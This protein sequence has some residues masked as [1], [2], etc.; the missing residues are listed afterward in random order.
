MRQAG[1]A[2]PEYRA[3]KEKYTFVELVQNPELAAEVTLQPIRRFDFDAAILFSDILVINEGLG[4]RYAFKEGGG[5]QME[6][7]VETEADL[8]RLDVK[9]VNPRLEYV[10]KALPLIR[11]GLGDRTALIGFAGSPW[12]LANFMVEGGGVKEYSKAKGWF[13]ENPAGFEKLMRKLTD[14][15]AGFLQLQID[16]GVDAVQIFDSLGGVL[17]EGSFEAASGRWIREIV[18]RLKGQVPV[19][20]FSK[21]THGN[22]KDLVSTGANI[23][24]MDWNVDLAAVRKSLPAKVGVQGNLDPYLLATSPAVV[25]AETKRILTRMRGLNGHIFNLGHGVTPKAKLEN[26]AALVNTVRSFK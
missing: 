22:W 10:A 13:Y 17:S 7:L 11:E 15:V 21:G 20:V 19:I 18:A 26:M 1:R 8:A 6:F 2:L 16:A 4:Q 24:G 23:L 25:E 5:I 3:L 14:A 12:T 9:A